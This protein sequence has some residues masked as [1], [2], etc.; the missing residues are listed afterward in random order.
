MRQFLEIIVPLILPTAIYFTYIILARPRGGGEPPEMPWIWLG[1]AGALLL[2]V[3]FVAIALFG[4]AAPTAKYL[5]P[6]LIDGKI[7]P[8]H[9]EP[10]K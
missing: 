6:K 1:L 3:T 2:I 4:G 5:P 8:G 9:F 7:Q 10:P